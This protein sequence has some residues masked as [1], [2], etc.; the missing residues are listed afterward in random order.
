[1]LN[2]VLVIKKVIVN[3]IHT[4]RVGFVMQMYQLSLQT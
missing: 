4:K 1:M 2:G 3:D